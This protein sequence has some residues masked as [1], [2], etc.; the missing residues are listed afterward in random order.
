MREGVGN[1]RKRGTVA[2]RDERGRKECGSCLEWL[3][4]DN[5]GPST[6]ASDGLTSWCRG[7]RSARRHGMTHVRMMD[8]IR[9]QDGLCPIC[10]VKLTPGTWRSANT[11]PTVDHD[12]GCCPGQGS[13]GRCVRGVLCSLCN[14][15]LGHAKDDPERLRMALKYLENQWN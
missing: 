8:M 10:L 9:A 7:C 11:T 4:V 2:N 6:S 15:M 14:R 1:Y 5:Y 3:S 12:H 13:C